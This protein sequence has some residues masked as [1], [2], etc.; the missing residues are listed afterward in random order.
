MLARCPTC[1]ISLDEFRPGMWRC[2]ACTGALVSD[3]ALEASLREMGAV[4]VVLGGVGRPAAVIRACPMCRAAMAAIAWSGQ[5]VDRCEAHGTWFDPGELAP[6]L[7][8]AGQAAAARRDREDDD[9]QRDGALGV[10][11]FVIGLFD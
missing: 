3:G 9:R 4:A 5:P 7:A 8:A 10:I 11:D 1:S 6:V 2:P